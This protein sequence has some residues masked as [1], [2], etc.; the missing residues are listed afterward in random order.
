MRN[1]PTKQFHGPPFNLF[2]NKPCF[3]GVYSASLLKTLWVKDE[4]LITSNSSFSPSVFYPFG[5]RSAIFIKFEIVIEILSVW[6]SLK[7]VV[8][9]RVNLDSLTVVLCHL[10]QYFSPIK[11]TSH[12]IHV[13]PG[14]HQ[15]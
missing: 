12:I 4:L 5:K 10:Q 2:L 7:F 13:Y 3:L 8:W 6:K 1:I 14:F 15:H 11:A 9:E